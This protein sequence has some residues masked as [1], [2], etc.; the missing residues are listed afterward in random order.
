MA[1][2]SPLM[3]HVGSY[4]DPYLDVG[5]PSPLKALRNDLASASIRRCAIKVNIG[6]ATDIERAIVRHWTG[7]PKDAVNAL[8]AAFRAVTARSR[9]EFGHVLVWGDVERMMARSK[10]FCEV[11]GLR[12][13]DE[14]IEGAHRRPYLPSID[15]IKSNTPYTPENCRLICCAVNIAINDWGDDVF[16]KIVRAAASK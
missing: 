8:S 11:T 16:W 3:S 5:K 10:G 1:L 2:E 4:Y 6:R 13:S 12:F 9:R 7:M 15:R 14:R